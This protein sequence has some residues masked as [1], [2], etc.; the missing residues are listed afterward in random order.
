MQ[1]RC[2]R[3]APWEPGEREEILAYAEGDMG[4]HQALFEKLLPLTDLAHALQRGRFCKAVAKMEFTGIPFD[5]AKYDEVIRKRTLIIAKLIEPIDK[6]FHVYEGTTFKLDRF[7]AYLAEQGITNWPTA[8]KG[9][10]KLKAKELEGV[11][12]QHEKLKP[13]SSFGA[14]LTRSESAR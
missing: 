1:D 8:P 3:G 5:V 10:P 13:H 11:L 2:A 12:A 6:A 14:S 7:L 9:R 4:L